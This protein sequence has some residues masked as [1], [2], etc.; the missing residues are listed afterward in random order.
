MF[1]LYNLLQGVG[2]VWGGS[3]PSL[4]EYC[5]SKCLEKCNKSVLWYLKVIVVLKYYL[6][7]VSCTVLHE[8][9]ERPSI[10][11]LLPNPDILKSIQA[12]MI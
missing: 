2:V 1:V 10:S 7:L 12:G 5:G 6:S 8:L 11:N 4:S 3:G 9:F